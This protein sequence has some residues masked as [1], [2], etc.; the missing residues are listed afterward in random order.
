MRW[1][2]PA[3]LGVAA[4][5]VASLGF[6]SA[7]HASKL[8]SRVTRVVFANNAGA[9]N[10]IKASRKPKPGKLVPLKKD[11]KFPDSVIPI[12]IETEGPQGPA[13]PP[14]A[15]GDTGPA[16][17]PGPIGPSGSSGLPGSQ[18]PQG[19]QGP[20]GPAGP[21]ISGFHIVSDQTDTNADSPKNLP[22]FCP[23]GERVI[24]GGA[25]VTGSGRVAL[26]SSVPFLS[27]GSSGWS[28]AA[29]EVSVTTDPTDPDKRVTTGQPS[30]FEWSLSVYA[31]CAK[32][33]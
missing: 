15:K 10:G 14:G 8:A 31:V 21:G 18:G 27:T 26:T 16:G 23:T 32:I 13:G 22:V 5:I 11:G 25:R 7:G 6:A 9:V 4:L 29:A 20:A 28:G 17:P 2:M 24:S 33:G 19:P 12:Q 3:A 30:D 1:R